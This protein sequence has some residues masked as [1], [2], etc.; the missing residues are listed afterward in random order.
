MSAIKSAASVI[1]IDFAQWQAVLDHTQTDWNMTPVTVL[2]GKRA[3]KI[4][5][6]SRF[7][8]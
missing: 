7:K 2:I 3:H 4:G 6:L 8:D 5:N 1:V